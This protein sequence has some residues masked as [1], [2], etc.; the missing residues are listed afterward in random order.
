MNIDPSHS[1]A[2]QALAFHKMENFPMFCNLCSGERFHQ[3]QNIF[4]VFEIS[5][6]KLT[7]YKRVPEDLAVHQTSAK[8]G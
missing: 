7:D 3:R 5:A 6:G 8:S 1:L 2:G 4:P